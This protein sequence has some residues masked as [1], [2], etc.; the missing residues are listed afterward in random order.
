MTLRNATDADLL[1]VRASDPEYIA[2]ARAEAEYW[3]THPGL[4]DAADAS[5]FRLAQPHYN[6]RYTGDEH[7]RWFETVHQYGDFKRGLVLGAAGI[8]RET[9]ILEH[10][11]SLHLT[12]MD[13][14]PGA[15]AKREAELGSKFPGRVTSIVADFNF[16]DLPANAYDLIVSSGAIHHVI[17]LEHLATQIQG[18]LTPD[19]WFFLEDYVGEPKR[20]IRPEK[21]LAYELIYNRDMTRQG[22]LPATLRWTNEDVSSSPFCT[23]RSADILP[24]LRRYL[25][26][27]KLRT[28]GAL[29]LPIIFAHDDRPLPL[30]RRRIPLRK[31]P[32]LRKAMRHFDRLRG[33]AGPEAFLAPEFVDRL[34]T[35]G[36]RLSDAGVLLPSNAFVIYRKA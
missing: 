28:T 35:V 25:H 6:R 21:K 4:A 10:N 30:P 16:V 5:Q 7:T 32:G 19:G 34:M 27:F 15:V 12:F 9:Y 17:N 13:I 23:I 8:L 26:E 22:R 18:A 24:V 11:S 36:D 2:M 20:E 29:W 33:H 3:G 14:S 1:R 31:I